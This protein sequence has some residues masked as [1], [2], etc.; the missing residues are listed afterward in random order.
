M[1]AIIERLRR[2]KEGNLSKLSWWSIIGE[3]E[4]KRFNLQ[5]VES[6]LGIWVQ[7]DLRRATVLTCYQA[8][9][10]QEIENLRRVLG[11]GPFVL[12][13]FGEVKTPVSFSH[14][15]LSPLLNFVHPS[16]KI[17][18]VN[19]PCKG[20]TIS[21]FVPI[22]TN[23]RYLAVLTSLSCFY[24]RPHDASWTGGESLRVY[25][26]V[27]CQ[28]DSIFWTLNT[29]KDIIAVLLS[30]KDKKSPGFTHFPR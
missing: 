15:E 12:Y 20:L 11:P 25:D 13:H 3:A 9:S 16:N 8:L 19:P 17:P 10:A 21:S 2:E 18:V 1:V 27:F 29:K 22:T 24:G 5:S 14:K 4:V 30:W 26:G 23:E 28:S 7:P 6:N